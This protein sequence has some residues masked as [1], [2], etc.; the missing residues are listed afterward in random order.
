MDTSMPKL[1]ETN[2]QN[3]LYN[4]LQKCHNNRVYLY[5]YVWNI[6]IVILF[7]V[8]TGITLY[9]CAN[10]KKNPEEKENQLLTEQHYILEKIRE[11][12]EH[13]KYVKSM[14]TITGLPL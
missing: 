8:I 2:T 5:S 1:I 9:L 7:I 13:E 12:K 3:Y 11:F 10:R 14:N 6:S 4:T